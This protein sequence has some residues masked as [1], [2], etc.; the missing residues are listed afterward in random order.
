[1]NTTKGHA[2]NIIEEQLIHLFRET[3]FSDTLPI[4]SERNIA[5]IALKRAAIHNVDD[6]EMLEK[7]QKEYSELGK[8]AFSFDSG[9]SPAIKQMRHNLLMSNIGSMNLEIDEIGS[10]LLG[11]ADA[12]NTYLEL[13]DVGKVKQKLTKNTKENIRSEEIEGR[14]PTNLLM[15]GTPS[16]LFDGSKVEEEFYSFL[17]TGYARRCIFGYSRNAKKN[18]VTT[19][20]EVYDAL[21]D[22]TVNQYLKDMAIKFGQLADSTNHNRVITVTKKVS[23]LVIEYRLYCE[24]LADDLGE[25]QEIAKAELAHRYFKALKLAG[26]Y[27]FID[28]DSEITEENYYHA[29]CMAEE[30]GRAFEKILSRDRTYVKLAKYLGTIGHEVTHVELTEDLPFYRGSA[31]A[32]QELIQLASAWGHKN[33]IIIKRSIVSGIEFFNGESLQKTDLKSLAL[34]YSKDISDG[35]Q[36]VQVAWDDL[37]KLTQTPMKHWINHH[38][39]DGHRDDTSIVSGFDM[40]VL[41]VDEGSTVQEVLLLLKKYSFLIHTTKRHT[42]QKHRFRIVMPM[43]YHLELTSS[44]YRKFMTN[45]YEW[46][47]MGVDT[48]TCQRSRKWVTCPGQYHYNKGERLLDARLFIPKTTKNDERQAFIVT[49]QSMTNMERWFISNSSNNRNN[50]LAR[51]ALMQVDLG[52]TI[53]T[54]KENV[55]AMNSKLPDKLSIKEITNTILASAAKKIQQ[56]AA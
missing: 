14:T 19:P 11:N 53:D 29:I 36:N 56:L 46:L 1:M 12:L 44:E 15:F 23:L 52:Y 18:K 49:H 41:D 6:D 2:T 32:K 42:A 31:T 28:G 20:E 22:I 21:T 43:N 17:E 27:A 34:S 47:P 38:S 9:T 30:S 50:Q 37:Y 35:Y 39:S 8:L 33:H 7:V 4:I 24:A 3:F 25:H 26:V 45:I 5:N 40:V 54:I 13:F 48:Q 16:K 10:N 55:L 51:Y